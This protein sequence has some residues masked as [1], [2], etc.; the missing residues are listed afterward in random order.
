MYGIKTVLLQVKFR[1]KNQA[2]N[3]DFKREIFYSMLTNIVFLGVACVLIYSPILP[4]TKIYK[5]IHAFPLWYLPLSVVLA[6]IIHDT[7]FYWMHRFLHLSTF[8]KTLHKTHHLSTNPSPWAAFSFHIG[9][10]VFEALIVFI[11]AFLIPIH[12]LMI[13]T[14]TLASLFINVYGHL[15]YEIMPLWFR[16]SPL[17][18]LFNS[19]VHHNMHHQYFNGNYGLYFRVWDKLMG[20][21]FKDYEEQFDKVKNKVV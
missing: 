17:F 6:L 10:S 11:V 5:D 13:F 2:T 8:Y 4:Y 9:E 15:G 18:Q 16:K 21:E 14:F 3:N 19:S 12:P 1:S 20:T 7:Y